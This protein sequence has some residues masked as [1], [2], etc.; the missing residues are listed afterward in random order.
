MIGILWWLGL[1]TNYR[2]LEM[3]VK[4]LNVSQ[5]VVWRWAG[6]LKKWRVIILGKNVR[7][8]ILH[9]VP[10]LAFIPALFLF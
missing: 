9:F 8:L 10:I 4:I 7:N 5:L 1:A 2:G 3:M 6:R